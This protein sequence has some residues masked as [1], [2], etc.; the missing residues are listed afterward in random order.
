MTI[1][2]TQYLLPAGQRRPTSIDM[3]LE[4]EKLA[5]ELIAAGFH[6]DIEILMTGMISMTCEKEDDCIAI[7][8]SENGPGIEVHVESLVRN[9]HARH[10]A[11]WKPNLE[12]E[13]E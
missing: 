9:A 12:E 2:F 10:L 11:G 1:P 8:V 3:P 6:F 7:A 13:P 4:V 5:H